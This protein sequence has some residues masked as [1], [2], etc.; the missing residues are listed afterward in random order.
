M[1]FRIEFASD[2]NWD[3]KERTVTIN[4]LK[5]LEALQKKYGHALIV[6][7]E[8]KTILVYDDYIE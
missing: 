2:W 3:E 4:S 5:E 8:E 1:K 7:F 6:D